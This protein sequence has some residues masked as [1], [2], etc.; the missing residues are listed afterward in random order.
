MD[1]KPI[2]REVLESVLGGVFEFVSG[3]QLG[4]VTMQEARASGAK[5]IQLGSN[6][7]LILLG[8]LR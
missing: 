5:V 8:Y 3:K 1:A 6:G 7:A 4:G 2:T